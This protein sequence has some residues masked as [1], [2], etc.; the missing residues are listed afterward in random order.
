MALSPR[1]HAS[2]RR[3]H[4]LGVVLLL[5][6]ACAAEPESTPTAGDA[7]TAQDVRAID[8]AASGD[9]TNPTEDARVRPP[10]DATTAEDAGVVTAE[11]ATVVTAD[12][13]RVIA[14]DATVA[15]DDASAAADTGAEDAGR[16]G[17][18]AQTTDLA[19]TDGGR[20]DAGRADAGRADAQPT[21]A[22]LGNVV[23]SYFGGASS[24]ELV[25]DQGRDVAVDSAGNWYVVGGVDRYSGAPFVPPL[26][27]T[28]GTR[29]DEDIFVLS[30]DRL[31]ALR[32]ATLIGGPAYDRP[33]AVEVDDA[34]H[35]WVAGRAG[36]NFPTTAGVFQP[37]FAGDTNPNGPYGTQDGFVLELNPDGSLA[38][39]TYVGGPG[40]DFIRDIDVDA[41][42]HIY[43]AVAAAAGAHPAV[44]AGAFVSA[45]PSGENTVVFKLS[46][47]GS[48]VLWGGYLG[49]SG[50][51]SSPPSLRVNAQGEAFVLWATTAGDAPTTAGAYQRANAGGS[52]L[53]V[54]RVAADGA[55]LIYAT[56]FGGSADELAE[57][58]QLGLTAADE[59][60]LVTQT[61]SALTLPANAYQR[62]I[63]GASDLLLAKLS[64][65]GARLT[66]ATYLGG[67]QGEHGEGLM[68]APSGDIVLTGSSQS[69]N[70]PITANAFQSTHRGRADG[71]VV[72]LDPGL[73]TLRYATFVGGGGAD[74]A[75]GVDVALD[76]AIVG[77]GQ[78]D[79]TNLLTTNALQPSS[80]GGRSDAFLFRLRP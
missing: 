50:N 78:T 25:G 5:L 71:I 47:N 42:G 61:T 32:F 66:A 22:S 79:S 72:V 14:D 58:H 36:V 23:L 56:Y 16:L 33:Y 31:G 24:V 34:G 1:H 67:A 28:I 51:E 6:S 55:S 54:A 69:P 40:R 18:D 68:V 15:P 12:D 45:P 52:D 20:V 11:D 3:V 70:F 65:D 17:P 59:A 19:S 77:T 4:P 21:D 29:D 73:T 62:T 13:A 43:A 8:A 26:G 35:V 38:W 60:V 39:A 53:V 49:G 64:A 48:S 46:P 9:A 75:R 41:T 2:T 44:T 27:R 57:T 10:D 63:A 37:T 30:F 76:G 7:M 80:G 74:T